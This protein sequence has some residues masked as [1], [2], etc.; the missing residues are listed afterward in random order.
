MDLPN[1]WSSLHNND[2]CKNAIHFKYSYLCF[3]NIRCF[4]HLTKTAT[5]AFSVF[6][7]KP[8]YPKT[9][10]IID[11]CSVLISANLDIHNAILT[12]DAPVCHRHGLF[13]VFFLCILTYLVGVLVMDVLHW[14]WIKAVHVSDLYGLICRIQLSEYFFVSVDF[15]I[16]ILEIYS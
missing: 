3:W 6:S 14:L 16:L 10:S 9:S 2:F 13:S 5:H 8:I 4:L 15:L 1:F 11:H 12:R 7:G